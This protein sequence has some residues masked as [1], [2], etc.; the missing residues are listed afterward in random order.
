MST[1]LIWIAGVYLVIGALMYLW[2][3]LQM[4]TRKAS[5]TALIVI[6]IEVSLLWLPII[7]TRARR[8]GK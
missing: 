5:V 8:P 1:V 3:V 2:V 7:L 4:D 6:M